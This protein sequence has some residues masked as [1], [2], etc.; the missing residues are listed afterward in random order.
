MTSTPRLSVSISPHLTVLAWI[1]DAL[2]GRR[3]GLPG[4]WRES[5]ASRVGPSGHRAVRPFAAPGHSVGPDCLV[6]HAPVGGDVSVQDQI[7]AL[8]DLPPDRLLADLEQAFGPGPLPVHWRSAADRPAAWLNGYAG[9][10]HDVWLSAEPVW[11]RARALLDREVRRVGVAGV[12]GGTQALLGS[13]NRRIG[14]DGRG[15]LIADIEPSVYDLGERRIVLVPML[16]GRDAVILSLDNRD[17]VW[18]AY[19]VPGADTLWREPA[20]PA[21]DELSALLGP[22]R[23]D[24]LYA[25]SRPMSMSM[26]AAGMRI[27]PSSITYHCDRLRAARLITK[28]RRGREV[29][30]GRTHRADELVELF[31]R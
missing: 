17:A 13:L 23:A 29:W 1:T 16:A 6:P 8:R 27:A 20:A 21:H 30:V 18:I 22:V 26:L 9:A 11:R 10:L 19:P 2:A 25:I 3:R 4:P 15:L 24:V 31:R 14:H 28:E 7:S 12:R 5:I